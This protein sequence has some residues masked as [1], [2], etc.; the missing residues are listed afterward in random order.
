M[1]SRSVIFVLCGLLFVAC[2][3]DGSD[4]SPDQVGSYAFDE[5]E[6]QLRDERRGRSMG[7]LVLF[8]DHREDPSAS[9]LVIFNHGF[10]LSSLG[11]RSY[12]EHLA[13]HGFVVALPTFPTNVL[14]VHHVKLAE[15]VRFVLD[16]LL[17][18][19]EDEEH[20]L[21]GRIDPERI[22]ASGHSLGGKLSLL[23]AVTDD[24]IDAI[25][26]LD[27]VDEGNPLW[28][29]PVRYPS[30]APE[31]MPEI[32]VPLL[33]VG[34]ELGKVLIAFSPCAPE[35]E[36]CQRFYEAANPP[37]IEITQLDVGHGQYVDE[38]TEEEDDPCARG[39]VPSEWVRSSS[40]AYLTAFFLGHLA[41]SQE[42]LDW[43][44][45]VKNG[46]PSAVIL[47]TILPK[48]GS[49]P[50]MPPFQGQNSAVFVDL[51]ARCTGRIVLDAH[52]DLRPRTIVFSVVPDGQLKKID[53]P[54][55]QR[56]FLKGDLWKERDDF[57][58]TLKTIV[59]RSRREH[60]TE[61]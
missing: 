12:G 39:D 58:E 49:V 42:A 17:L 50:A 9:P 13:S 22:G 57:K 5:L 60:R 14:D 48:G 53:F 20:A 31:L 41:D 33:F 28:E 29:D 61:S 7:L 43:L 54:P 32:H 10:L 26:V 15:D 59:E 30:V 37:A 2:V 52:K 18:V 24:R 19:N 40:S 21:F 36:N 6:V 25:G 16:Y 47:D 38:A 11:Y 4:V 23:E 35:G 3:S 51:Y 44:G 1:L 55:Y 46:R 34:A 56:A 45:D 27:P 8:P